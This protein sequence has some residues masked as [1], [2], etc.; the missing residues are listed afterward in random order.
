MLW[1]NNTGSS[2]TLI[3]AWLQIKDRYRIYTGM[4]AI[5]HWTWFLFNQLISKDVSLPRPTSHSETLKPLVPDAGVALGS[6][7]LGP[8]STINCG[9]QATA[10]SNGYTFHRSTTFWNLVLCLPLM[11]AYE[12]DWE[13]R[14]KR[15]RKQCWSQALHLSPKPIGGSHWEMNMRSNPGVQLFDQLCNCFFY[16]FIVQ[17]TEVFLTTIVISCLGWQLNPWCKPMWRKQDLL[18][19]R[20]RS[21]NLHLWGANNEKKYP[22][23]WE[24]WW[25][26]TSVICL[27][28]VDYVDS[29]LIWFDL[30]SGN[31]FK[32]IP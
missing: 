4:L 2:V 32:W 3:F 31:V 11:V 30:N 13:L 24:I 17:S 25:N 6:E 14:L 20:Q 1:A 29:S 12:F 16:C 23:F 19:I 27:V 5:F 10:G 15:P 9:H 28:Q 8:H 26:V 18:A 22:S 7:N 21:S